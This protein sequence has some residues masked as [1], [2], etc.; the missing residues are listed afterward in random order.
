MQVQFIYDVEIL[1]DGRTDIGD[2]L[3]GQLFG[4]AGRLLDRR[5]GKAKV[6]QLICRRG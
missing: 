6:R 1:V 4:W 5:G 2:P 3:A